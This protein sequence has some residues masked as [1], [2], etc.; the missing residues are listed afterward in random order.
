MS[1]GKVLPQAP[2]PELRPL[3]C[4]PTMGKHLTRLDYHPSLMGKKQEVGTFK[5]Q[6]GEIFWIVEFP[7]PLPVRKGH[8]G[9]FFCPTRVSPTP[10]GLGILGLIKNLYAVNQTFSYLILTVGQR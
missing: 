2:L 8:L 10:Q 5:T 4:V 6:N 1:H 9:P 3:Y 7:P